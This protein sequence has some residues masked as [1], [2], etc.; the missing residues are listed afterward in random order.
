[1]WL[2]G[3][4]QKNVNTYITYPNENFKLLLNKYLTKY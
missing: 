2:H 3:V 1:M 4:Y